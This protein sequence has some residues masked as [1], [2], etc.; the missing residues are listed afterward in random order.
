MKPAPAD[1]ISPVHQRSNHQD[2]PK[3]LE[4]LQALEYGTRK[5]ERDLLDV[6]L[7]SLGLGGRWR[8]PALLFASRK[9]FSPFD[10]LKR[11]CRIPKTRDPVRGSCCPQWARPLAI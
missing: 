8:A 7:P 10:S 4:I 5:E 9:R 11:Q 1:R 3:I 2:L 6:V